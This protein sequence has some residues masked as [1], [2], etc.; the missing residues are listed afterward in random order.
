M[1][2]ARAGSR[3]AQLV[4]AALV[5]LS[6]QGPGTVAMATEFYVRGDGSGSDSNG[7]TGWGD[8]FA[9]LDKALESLTANTEPTTHKVYVQASAGAQAYDVAYRYA[10]PGHV[11]A[12]FEGG[13]ED[14]GGTPVQTGY[15]RV[16]DTDG[17]VDERGFYFS[18]TGSTHNQMKYFLFRRF[19][20]S[21][22]TDGIFLRNQSNLSTSA[23]RLTLVDSTINCTSNGVHLEW[24]KAYQDAQLQIFATNVTVSA[25]SGGA[26]NGIYLYGEFDQS[27]LTNVT[28]T[29]AGNDGIRLDLIS[30]RDASSFTV[31]QTLWIRNSTVSG[32]RDNGISL[33]PAEEPPNGGNPTIV[34]YGLKITDNGSDG[35]GNGVRLEIDTADG[36]AAR[37]MSLVATNCVVAGNADAGVY[38]SGNIDA[39]AARFSGTLVNCTVADNGSD[40][41]YG[42]S[43]ETSGNS[44]TAYNTIFSGN[45][46]D[47]IEVDDQSAAGPTI[48]ETYND[49]YG[50]GGSD[51]VRTG[52]GGSTTPALNANDLA[53]DPRFAGSE[54]PEP[55]RLKFNSTLLDAASAAYAP[56]NDILGEARPIGAGDAMGAYE[57]P[58]PPPSG[59]VFRI[60]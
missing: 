11:F 43:I 17:V 20:F 51:L 24:P 14:V 36:Y 21:N 8:A 38:F 15:S 58:Q 34:L 33:R 22:V 23:I 50:Q 4:S 59:S 3:L 1:T 55:Y 41:V 12:D 18:A 37:T 32:C 44:V 45:G 28:V 60:R 48:T 13:W 30:K 53:A 2:T 40:G 46:D 42:I 19:Q 54:A 7:G 9:T 35:S 56:E 31:S 47:G 52:T 10:N 39:R 16:Q 5:A 57:R 6:V 49:F 27:V 29:S 25:G 26:G